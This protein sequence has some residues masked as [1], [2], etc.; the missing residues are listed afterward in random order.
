MALPSAAVRMAPGRRRA[1]PS[2]PFP[3]AAMKPSWRP[4]H[5]RRATR[6]SFWR[7]PKMMSTLSG[8]TMKITSMPATSRLPPL[9]TTRPGRRASSWVRQSPA[10]PPSSIRAARS[11][12]PTC[13]P[14]IWTARPAVCTCAGSRSTPLP[15][16]P[17]RRCTSPAIIASRRLQPPICGWRQPGP[18]CWSPG[19][20]PHRSVSGL[21]VRQT[22]A[23]AG[24]ICS[25]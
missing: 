24:T 18:R 25:C 14:R 1:S 3:R 16:A 20:N 7:G 17:P 22:A 11:I 23:R 6:R 8:A 2:F 12:W 15:G 13:K 9:R 10:W 21:P 4:A 5:P 19:L